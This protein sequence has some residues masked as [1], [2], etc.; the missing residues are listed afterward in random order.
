[1]GKKIL[2]GLVS[3]A[4]IGFFV[5]QNFFQFGSK[6]DFGSGH[7][8]YYK[9]GATE[10]E[11]KRVGESLTMLGFF[12]A[13]GPASVQ[14]VKE[15]ETFLVRFVTVDSAWSDPEAKT[16]FSYIG[17]SLSQ[18]CFAGKPVVIELCD[19][20]FDTKTRV[21]SAQPPEEEISSEPES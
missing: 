15:G 6:V 4:F 5:Y 11:A 10:T 21:E 19:T 3:V 16:G 12:N 2:Q 13:D 18:S 1:M 7:E 8:V 17:W 9:G 20:S 14:V